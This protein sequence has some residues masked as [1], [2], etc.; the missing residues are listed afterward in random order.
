MVGGIAA[1]AYQNGSINP[2]TI[3]V[4]AAV[5]KADMLAS[6]TT[7]GPVVTFVPCLF[8]PTGAPDKFAVLN[9]TQI[10]DTVR[11]I[12]RRTLRVGE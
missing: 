3:G 6:F 4:P 11:V 2:A 1:D 9:S 10:E 5:F 8:N 7:S 12:H